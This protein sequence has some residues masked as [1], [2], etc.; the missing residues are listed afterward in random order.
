MTRTVDLRQL[1]TQAKELRRAL[2]RRD[3]AALARLAAW[4]PAP[5]DAPTLR[6]AQLVIAASMATPRGTTSCTRS[7]PEWW[8]SATCTAG[9]PSS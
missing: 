6:D 3:P 9:S 8:Q 1:R 4:H 2:A 5:A 7:A